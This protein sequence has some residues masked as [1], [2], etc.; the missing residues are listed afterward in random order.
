MAE[1]K[2]ELAKAYVQVI[3]TTEGIGDSLRSALSGVGEEAGSSAGESAG[4]GFAA[5]FGAV[6]KTTAKVGAV[7]IGAIASA[8]VA[9][10]TALTK[11]A[12]EVA[13]YGDNIDK[14]SQKMGIS[15]TAYQEWDAILQHSGAS[16]SS[17]LPSMKTMAVQAQKNAAEFQQLGISQEEVASLS[18]EELFAKVISGL[19][20]MGEGTE[21]TALASKLLGR[22]A[23]ELGALLNTSAEDTE[24]MRQKL[25]E[26]GGVM[27]D[28]A[29][30]NAAAFQ[31]SLQDMQTAFAGV[32]NKVMADLL[33]S[34]TSIMDGLA[35]LVSG[36]EGAKEQLT[37]GVSD[38]VNGITEKL[39]EIVEGVS[40]VATAIIEALPELIVT[41]SEALFEQLPDL[42]TMV[43][44]VGIQTVNGLVEALP[45]MIEALLQG[46]FS[47]ENI[48]ALVKGLFEMIS[49]IM[50]N[51]V[52]IIT[53]IIESLPD[54]LSNVVSALIENLPILI[55]GCVNLIVD[56]V[57]HLPEIIAALIKAIPQVITS[58][59]NAFLSP[60][61]IKKW[62][63]IGTEAVEHIK[64]AF[65]ELPG[66]LKE[67]FEEAKEKWSETWDNIK[68]KC[69]P[70]IDNIRDKF[71]ELKG[72][73]KEVGKDIVK[74]LW[75]GINS[76]VDWIK[77]KIGGWCKKIGG[78]I[79]DFFGIASP[80]KLM[81]EYGKYIDEGLATGIEKNSSIATNAMK[82]L[83]EDALGGINV[84]GVVQSN[85]M[86]ASATPSI[87][88]DRKLDQIEAL[89]KKIAEGQDIYLDGNKLVGA[90]ANRMNAALDKI[91]YSRERGVT[92]YAY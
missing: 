63:S 62:V 39:P 20:E 58:I 65:T 22:G 74:G 14:M 17:L 82:E 2:I 88:S 40:A 78:A 12:S 49:M 32:K 18:Q 7:A 92:N 25:H 45:Q 85:V 27:S 68:E 66:K 19:Q 43:V 48:N 81:A 70:I 23:T 71:K 5:K 34:F 13:A 24:A 10:G 21:R 72:K 29:V 15:A 4:S 59:V 79:K 83:G 28:E 86:A 51:W 3:P 54:I 8:G 47:A 50:S 91:S 73:L 6:M 55:E 57:T 75:N 69:A 11:G 42:I 30:K 56:L 89:L 26:L 35:G 76:K 41:L 64:E 61:S 67:K 1:N 90:T 16:I 44:D 36:Q 38:M 52:D 80:S 87:A 60:E 31:D 37:A 84:N 46:L 33:P 9:M 53:P 77:E